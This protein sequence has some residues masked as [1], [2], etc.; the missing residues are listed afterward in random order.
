VSEFVQVKLEDRTAWVTLNR[1]PLNILNI[2]MMCEL[3]VA[4][5][6]VAKKCDFLLLKGEGP[7]GFSAGAD[8]ADH[9][10][11]RVGKMLK[12]FHAIFRRLAAADC[13]TIAVVHGVCLGGGMELATFCD[14]VVAAGTAEFGQ[15]EIKLGCFPP[16]ALVTLPDLV[17]L[18]AATDIIL[19]GRQFGAP[20]AQLYRLVARVVPD[21]QLAH[22]ANELL[23]ELR[24]ISPAVLRLTRRTLWRLHAAEFSK[25]L[26][27]VE[28]L[29]LTK[30]MKF[31]DAQEGVRA[32]LEKRP[33]VWEGS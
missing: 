15:P 26:A 21:D 3:D 17:G 24:Q 28:R 14:F 25:R 30:L 16:V 22:A 8:V 33:P 10:P 20:E 1:P 13:T 4:L 5:K 6:S 27:E 23:A 29:Y 12:S 31:K 7:K 18:R 32:F 19:T 9:T 2:E 11:K